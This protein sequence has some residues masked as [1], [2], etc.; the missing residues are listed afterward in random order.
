MLGAKKAED[1]GGRF[2]VQ[3]EFQEND[4]TD[5][6][7]LDQ[8]GKEFTAPIGTEQGGP[9]VCID[10]HIKVVDEHIDQEKGRYHHIHPGIELK[11]GIGQGME[12]FKYGQADHQGEKGLHDAQ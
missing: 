4:E 7:T 10:L 6:G 8:W 9:K 11:K 3:F 2:S 1:E 5:R 12:L